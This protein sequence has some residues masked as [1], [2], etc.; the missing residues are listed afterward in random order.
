MNGPPV[1]GKTPIIGGRIIAPADSK[2]Y[3][4]AGLKVI[5]TAESPE[6]LLIQGKPIEA[7]VMGLAQTEERHNKELK[8]LTE[9]LEAQNDEIILLRE[10]I[11]TLE[12]SFEAL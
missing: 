12:I 8:A 2:E 9:L 11:A 10:K 1:N 5:T 3:T 6:H 7:L 4:F